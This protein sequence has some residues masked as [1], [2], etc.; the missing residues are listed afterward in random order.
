[1]IRPFLVGEAPAFT[2]HFNGGAVFEMI[3]RHRLYSCGG[4]P[5]MINYLFDRASDQL[6]E[7]IIGITS[8]GAGVP[9]KLVY[10]AHERGLPMLRTYGSTEHPTI[11]GGSFADPLEHRANTDGRPLPGVEVRIVDDDG[12]EMPRGEPGEIISMGPELFLG[13]LD[14]ELNKSAFTTDG[15]FHTGDI[16]VLNDEGYLTIIDRKKDIIIRGGE[17]ISSQEVEGIPRV[18]RRSLKRQSLRGPMISMESALTRSFIY[19]PE[20]PSI[21]LRS[22]RT[23]KGLALLARRRPSTS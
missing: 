20:P 9:P 8:G 7:K 15:W 11:S 21:L 19:A 13:Y 17:N 10:R 1:M 22:M 12:N 3:K 14:P 16:G 18:I 6:I 5:F 23:S 4:A 2:D